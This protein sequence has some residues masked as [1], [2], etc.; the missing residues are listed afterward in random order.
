MADLT[1]REG[2]CHVVSL[3]ERIIDPDTEEPMSL[4][5]LLADGRDDCLS[6]A[7]RDLDW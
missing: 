7:T 3:E 2:H 1:Q 5:E 4:G 6:A